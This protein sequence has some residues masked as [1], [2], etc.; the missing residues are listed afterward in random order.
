MHKKGSSH[1]RSGF[2]LVIRSGNLNNGDMCGPTIVN[3]NNGVSNTWVN[4]GSS[5]NFF[6]TEKHWRNEVPR[7]MAKHKLGLE[8][9]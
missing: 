3:G 2:R 5:L 4:N 9:L 8:Y 7:H 6:I 1:F